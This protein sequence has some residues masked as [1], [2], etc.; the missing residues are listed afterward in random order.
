MVKARVVEVG[1]NRYTRAAN[2]HDIMRCELGL[3]ANHAYES[4]F[5]YLKRLVCLT[6]LH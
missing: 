3:K 2:P 5:S 6:S 1:I 4:M